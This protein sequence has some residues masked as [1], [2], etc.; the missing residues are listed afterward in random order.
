VQLAGTQVRR[1]SMHNASW[2][3]KMDVRLGDAVVVEKAGEIIP[4]VVGIVVEARTGVEQPIRWPGACP[5]CGAAIEKQESAISYG[6]VCTGSATCPA[7]LTQRLIGFAKRDRMDIDG[8]GEEVAKQLVES[9]LVRS[10]ADLYSL[11]ERQLLALEGFKSKKA[12]NL[13]AGIA[14]SK[15]RGL[16]RLLASLSIY[17][18]GNSMAKPL[19]DEFPSIEAISEASVDDLAR[20]KGVGPKRAESVVSFFHSPA[21]EALVQA[22]RNAGVNMTHEGG[23]PAPDKQPLRGKTCV[24]TGTLTKFDR[25]EIEALIAKHGG[26]AG[27][28]VS[29]KTHYLIA[30]ENAGSKLAKA[31]E[32]GVAILSEDE[33]LAII[34]ASEPS[35]LL[36]LTEI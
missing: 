22:L 13:V 7:Q 24:V 30:G 26:K 31:Q 12:K 5:V 10:V 21:G 15:G 23:K 6:Y 3:E 25:I 19:A 4:Q 9:E 11:A 1:A 16:A 34:T 35:S 28:S 8:L 14:S 17:G 29:K 27:G 32:L 2:V 20:V 33:F 36:R 18:V